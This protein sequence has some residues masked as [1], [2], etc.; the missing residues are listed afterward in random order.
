[1]NSNPQRDQSKEAR[2]VAAGLTSHGPAADLP[3]AIRFTLCDNAISR[4]ARLKAQ[5]EGPKNE[6]RHS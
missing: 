3:Y 2:A 1:M 6:H 5:M 4:H